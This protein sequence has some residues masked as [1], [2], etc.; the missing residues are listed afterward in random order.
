MDRRAASLRPYR[1]RGGPTSV[2][3]SRASQATTATSSTTWVEEVLQRQSDLSATS[4]LRPPCWTD[5]R[6]AVRCRHGPGWWQGDA[7][8]AGARNLFIVPL[9]DRR[10]WYRYHHVFADVLRARLLDKQPGNP[11]HLHCRASRG[12]S[13][14][15]TTNRADTRAHTAQVSRSGCPSLTRRPGACCRGTESEPPTVLGWLRTTPRRGRHGH[16]QVRPY[17]A[18]ALLA[19]GDIGRDWPA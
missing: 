17:V 1:C 18:E 13:R 16:R 9:D 10:L 6:R 3:S 5:V 14:Q 2:V 8:G 19:C 12:T 15:S 11:R 4:Y 7:G